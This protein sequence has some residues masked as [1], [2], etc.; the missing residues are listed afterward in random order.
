MRPYGCA[1]MIET[2]CMVPCA[3][4]HSELLIDCIDPDHCLLVV[5]S[6]AHL[7]EALCT[8]T[9][10]MHDTLGDT[11]PVK[12]CKL[13]RQL[14]VLQQNGP[15][16]SSCQRVVVVPDWR[17]RVGGPVRRVVCRAGTNLCGGD[18][19]RTR[20]AVVLQACLKA[21]DTIQNA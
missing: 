21:S 16:H 4:S 18:G 20:T 9:T 7:K 1:T 6:I 5:C 10:G 17:T 11:L 12:V 15:T 14:V 2:S 8:G 19:L 3:T 13:L